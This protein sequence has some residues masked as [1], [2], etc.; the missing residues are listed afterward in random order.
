MYNIQGGGSRTKSMGFYAI[1]IMEPDMNYGTVSAG[2]E[3]FD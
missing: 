1:D 3:E 2:E